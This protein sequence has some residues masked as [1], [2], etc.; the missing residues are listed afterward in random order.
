MFHVSEMMKVISPP[1]WNVGY[2]VCFNIQY[3]V[4]VIYM[5]MID[6]CVYSVKKKNASYGHFVKKSLRF[7]I[8]I[9]LFLESPKMDQLISWSQDFFSAYPPVGPKKS[10]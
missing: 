5:Y 10:G 8:Q 6:M 4:Y 2:E 7:H 3:Y 9:P 1:A